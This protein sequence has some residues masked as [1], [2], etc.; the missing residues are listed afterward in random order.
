MDFG[1][2]V[3]HIVKIKPSKTILKHLHL[4]REQKLWNIKVTV[5]LFVIDVLGAIPT[6][7]LKKEEVLEIRGQENPNQ[8]SALLKSTRILRRVLI[9]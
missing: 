2:A 3:D 6:G 9:S 5:I 8:T 1:L 4:A 7:L